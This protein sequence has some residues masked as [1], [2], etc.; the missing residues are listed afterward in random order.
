MA[1]M[2]R[3]ARMPDCDAVRRDVY[4]ML[5]GDLTPARARAIQDHLAMCRMC[6]PRYEFA[7]LMRSLARA[8]AGTARA[9]PSLLRRVRAIPF[10]R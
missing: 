5:A 4:R 3:G 2:V 7:A 6:F 1:S 9:S 10:A 8:A